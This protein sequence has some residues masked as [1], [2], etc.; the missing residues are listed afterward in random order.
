[1]GS[2]KY[3]AEATL[4]LPDGDRSSYEFLFYGQAYPHILV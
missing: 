4:S 1:M 2:G 3:E